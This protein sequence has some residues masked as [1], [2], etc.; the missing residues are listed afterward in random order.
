MKR[1]HI[2][3]GLIIACFALFIFLRVLNIYYIQDNPEIL[4]N[5]FYIDDKFTYNLI[6]MSWENQTHT[7]LTSDVHPPAYYYL[8][9]LYGKFVHFDLDSLRLLTVF[10]GCLYFIVFWRVTQS[11]KWNNRIL[12]GLFVA[13]NPLFIQIDTSLRFYSLGIGLLLLFY[14]EYKKALKGNFNA[15]FWSLFTMIISSL[16]NYLLALSLMALILIE[17]KAFKPILKKYFYLLFI[18]IFPFII[19]LAQIK[20]LLWA[21]SI[22]QAS[23]WSL[24]AII[25]NI[26]RYIGSSFGIIPQGEISTFLFFAPIVLLPWLAYIF[27]EKAFK[28]K[29]IR[30]HF[31]FIALWLVLI[32]LGVF[33]PYYFTIKHVYFTHFLS[34][35][36]WGNYG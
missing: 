3:R 20:Y 35:M 15:G 13:I 1:N 14:I 12:A 7:L 2:D 28:D 21:Q 5:D 4:K 10:F 34:L 25:Y 18:L 17:W 9:S 26:S 27:Y 33:S 6:Q 29:I 36:A 23:H 22:S 31:G 19:G 16:Y 30:L 32:V 8:L 11:W 24:K